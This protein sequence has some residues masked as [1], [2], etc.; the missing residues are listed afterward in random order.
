MLILATPLP[1]QKVV[2]LHRVWEDDEGLVQSDQV[3]QKPLAQD[4]LGSG[5]GGTGWG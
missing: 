2:S 1:L 5:V 3:A 4:Q